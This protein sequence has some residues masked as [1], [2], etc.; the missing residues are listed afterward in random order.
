M[1]SATF[2]QHICKSALWD[3]LQKY[4]ISIFSQVSCLSE[5]TKDDTYWW[6]SIHLHLSLYNFQILLSEWFLSAVYIF[7]YQFFPSFNLENNASLK[8]KFLLFWVGFFLNFG[9]HIFST[10]PDFPSKR[11]IKSTAKHICDWMHLP[12]NIPVPVSLNI[13]L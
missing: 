2:N 10:R 5:S 1:V 9:V 11:K 12:P 3:S 7:G 8:L 4:P 13:S 6:A